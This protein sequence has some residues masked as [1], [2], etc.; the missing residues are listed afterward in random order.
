MSSVFFSFMT[1]LNISVRL[2]MKTILVDPNLVQTF[3]DNN[4]FDPSYG[5]HPYTLI[6]FWCA[7]N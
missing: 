6:I 5:A 2:S 7:V 3:F 1:S 4:F